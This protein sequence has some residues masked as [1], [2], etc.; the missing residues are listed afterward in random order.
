[1]SPFLRLVWR[2]ALVA[3]AVAGFGGASGPAAAQSR[4]KAKPAA[5]AAA[6]PAVTLGGLRIVA[7][8]MGE[9]GTEI[10]GVNATF[11]ER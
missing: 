6:P 3:V 4:G 1:M 5:A 9:E 8:G 11:T 10:R 2:S 7:P